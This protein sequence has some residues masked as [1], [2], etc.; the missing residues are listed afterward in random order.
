MKV[1]LNWLRDFVDINISAEELAEKLTNSGNEVEEIIYQDKY[2]K[3]VVVGRIKEIK[4]HPNAEKLVICQVDIGEKMTQIITAAKNIKEND[5]VPVSLPGAN[6][7]N[8]I[9]ITASKL[10][11]EDSFGMFCSIEELGVTDYDGEVNGIMILEEGLKEGTPIAD[12]LLM[13]DVILDVNVTSNRPDCMSIVGIA[14]EISALL[15]VPMKEKNYTYKTNKSETVDKYI[16]VEVQNPE[17]CPR[18]MATAVRNIKIQKS[19]KWLR[20]RLVAVDVKPINNIVDITN[21]V[22]F[23]YGQPMH[24]F[25]AQYLDGNKII[26]RT[27]K[28]G[29]SIKVLNQNTYQLTDSMLCICD[30]NKPVVI[31]GII[32]GTNSCVSDETTNIVFEAASFERACVRRTSRKIGVRT[33]STARFEK[34]VDIGSPNVGMQRALSL[35]DELNAGTIIDGVIDT[36]KEKIE[37]KTLNFSLSRIFKILG[38]KIDTNKIEQ[39]LTNLGIPSKINGDVLTCNV[40]VYRMD[41]ED[42]AD[43]AEEII[44]MYGYDVYDTLEAV[45]PLKD[46][47]YSVGKYDDVLYTGRKIKLQLCDYGYD[48]IL[49]YSICSNDVIDKLL[50]PKNSPLTNMIKIQ[51]PISEDIGY[52]RT[53]MVN[54]MLLSIDR[55]LKRKNKDFKFFEMGRVYIPESLPI[56]K[57]PTE[58]DCISF[59]SILKSDNFFTLKGIV[60]NILANYDINYCLE[61]SKQSYLHPGISADV[62]DTNSGEMIAHFG[63]IHPKV[64]KNFDISEKVLYGEINI[65]KLITY[66]EKKYAVKLLSKYPVVERDIAVIC[67]ENVKIGDMLASIKKSCG[68]L[69]YDCKL[70]DIYR[71]PSLGENKKSLA[72]NIKLLSYDKTLTDD[73]IN[74]CVNKTIKDLTYKFGAKLR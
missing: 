35:I 40:P 41:I 31:A 71:N 34:G 25:D 72:F 64:L 47:K 52:V 5:L 7:A 51:N 53:T 27:A 4:Q 48:E 59:A 11:G 32:G 60:E 8:G 2:L 22:L 43:I 36:V 13:N 44:R 68:A 46:A 3:N 16:S 33:D 23:E 58:I 15:G 21:Y 73:E 18:Y 20:A 63:E 26:V 56:E 38:I 14:R 65:S 6:L 66:P 17:L 10:R 62:I 67:D 55:N 69:F 37:P 49:N 61:Y 29:E 74:A 30:Q 57:T 45:V 70:F 50:L 12:A 19:P 39:I 9:S 54:G 28:N 1:T 42:D 24:A